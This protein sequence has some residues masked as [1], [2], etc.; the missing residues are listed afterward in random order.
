MTMIDAVI[1][2]D[3]RS[4]HNVGSII[5]TCDGFGVKKVYIGGITPYPR[6]IDDTRLPHIVE[7]L[8][9]DI[10]KSAL[11]AEITTEIHHY[12]SIYE[13]INELKKSNFR[14]LALEQSNKSININE[15]FASKNKDVMLIG[16]EVEGIDPNILKLCDQV[17]EIPMKG[18]KESFNVSVATGIALFQLTKTNPKQ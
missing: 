9:K 10:A 6:I 11:G 16:R 7:K 12:D 15:A 5:R 17:L 14:V 4:S 3:I 13:L 8:T 2:H 1:L 18:Q